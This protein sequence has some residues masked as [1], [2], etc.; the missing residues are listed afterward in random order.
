[1]VDRVEGLP[2]IEENHGRPVA[3]SFG[4]S[5]EASDSPKTE[6]PVDLPGMKPDCCA[7]ISLFSMICVSSCCWTIFPIIL[8]QEFR[9][10]IGLQL[11]TSVRF[12][13]FGS[14]MMVPTF[15]GGGTSHVSIELFNMVSASSGWELKQSLMAWVLKFSIPELLSLLMA[16]TS[17]VSVCLCTYCN[18]IGTTSHH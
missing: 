10:L 7:S 8:E 16:L 2:Q 3:S 14:G 9:R 11:L 5:R 17:L 1:M 4:L 15:H 12:P 6:S 18:S 13:V